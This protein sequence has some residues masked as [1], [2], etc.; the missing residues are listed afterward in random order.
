MIKQK[1]GKKIDGWIHIAFPFLFI[2]E[3]NPN[4][5]TVVGVLVSCIRRRDFHGRLVRLHLHDGLVLGHG[6]ALGHH[7]ADDL[8]LG[9]ALTQIRKYEITRHRR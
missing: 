1:L 5:L 8:R 7:Q 4:L 9:D 3:L 6:L 2:R